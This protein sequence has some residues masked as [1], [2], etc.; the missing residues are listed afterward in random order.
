MGDSVFATRAEEA[1]WIEK[2]ATKGNVVFLKSLA[3]P[4]MSYQRHKATVIRRVR[5]RV[6]AR[7]LLLSRRP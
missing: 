1:R 5:E 6:R 2:S 3:M 4:R 7:A